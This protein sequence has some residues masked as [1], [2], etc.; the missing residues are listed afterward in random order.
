[1][2]AFELVLLPLR[3][4]LLLAGLVVPGAALLR[5]LR[6]PFTFA[7][8][9]LASAALLITSVIVLATLRLPLTLVTFSAA[10]ALV[11]AISLIAPK[12]FTSDSD[13]PAPEDT[14]SFAAFTSLGRWAP[15][16]VI[17]WATVLWRLGTQPL[18]GPDVSFRWGWLAEQI[19]RLGTLD[20]Y[21]PRTAADFS[22]YAWPESIPPGIAALHAWAWLCGGSLRQLWLAPVVLLQLLA[23]HEF[24]WRLAFSWGGEAAARRAVL[25]AAATPLLTW[26]T[27]IGQE[28]GL[29]AL[30]VCGLFFALLRW[31]KTGA[32]AW[33]VLAA[34]A[35]VAGAGA[36]EYGLAFPL[37]GLGL[38]ALQRA[39][40]AD[41]LRFAAIAL[42]LSALWPLRT[43]VLTGNPFFTL[44]VAGLFPTN[45]VF[46][47][48]SAQFHTAS[49]HALFTLEAWQQLARYGVLFAPL[50]LAGIVALALHAHRGL[51]E[52]RWCA[53]CVI[54]SAALWLASVGFTAGG[55]F[56]SL[57]VLSP[58][59][60]LLS[61][62]TGYAILAADT[63]VRRVADI[64]L[65]VTLLATLPS[66]LTL[67]ENAY[68]T[69][70][71]DWPVTAA[72]F[73]RLT[74]D[75][76]A[77]LATALQRLP[78]HERVLTDFA[79]L[80]PLLA[81]TSIVTVP[82]WS[83]EA[84]WLFDPATSLATAATRWPGLR[85]RYLI[86]SPNLTFVQQH[87]RWASPPFTV[88]PIWRSPAFLILEVTTSP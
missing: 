44:N 3:L 41:L 64:L 36:R 79:G 31:L 53:V 62:F 38:L 57:R 27:L 88:R 10:L 8:S 87:A 51:R 11:T 69:S 78:G 17:F 86:T 76:A 5:A 80:S 67:P 55:L 24:I 12:Y 56:Y 68:H 15:L 42:P 59:V 77:Q 22:A 39:S 26:A 20:F 75:D 19:V 7:G 61:A 14:Q 1:M 50:A 81:G 46:A 35:A 18:S 21:P 6:L 28:T 48:W 73:N 85:I 9:F 84:A 83:P 37:L 49:R 45:A 25:A 63:P 2:G 4:T 71:R 40:Y 29:T 66:T 43:W 52:A 72:R 54:V 16:Y 32:A 30:S 47:A 33:L 58:A 74:A 34:L 23:L 65:A 70:P 82:F 60:A 13:P